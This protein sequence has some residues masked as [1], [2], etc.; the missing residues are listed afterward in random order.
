MGKNVLFII[1]DQHQKNALGCYGHEFVK[2][3]NMDKL[4]S[5]GTRF[6]TAYTSSPVCVPARAV[7]ATGKYIFE[8]GLQVIDK[9]LTG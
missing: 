8:T 9:T 1:S 3:P 5:R 2:T 6:S 4:A 7:I